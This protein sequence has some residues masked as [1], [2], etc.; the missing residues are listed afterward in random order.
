ML[1]RKGI[2]GRS[3]SVAVAPSWACVMVFLF[4][5]CVFGVSFRIAF[6]CLKCQLR[7]SLDILGLERRKQENNDD[8]S[9]GGT[10]TAIRRY[11]VTGAGD[12]P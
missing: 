7:D 5:F 9:T 6:L 4:L 12:D 11:W 8:H 2:V 3:F 1:V 10:F